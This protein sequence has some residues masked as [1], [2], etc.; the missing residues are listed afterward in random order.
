MHHFQAWP[1]KHAQPSTLCLLPVGV[2]FEVSKAFDGRISSRVPSW[3][4]LNCDMGRNQLVF[5]KA[6][7]IWG[8]LLEELTQPDNHVPLNPYDTHKLVK[9]AT[10]K[11]SSS[12]Q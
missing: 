2:V 6:T 4:P 11:Q 8:I 5:Y 1:I 10:V 7:E 9:M 3:L 12:Q